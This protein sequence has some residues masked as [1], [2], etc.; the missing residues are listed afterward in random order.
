MPAVQVSQLRTDILEILDATA[1]GRYSSALL[2]RRIGIAQERLYALL[3]RCGG[4][5]DWLTLTL[6]IVVDPTA[7]GYSDLRELY[8]SPIAAGTVPTHWQLPDDRDDAGTEPAPPFYRLRSIS[9]V[10]SFTSSGTDRYRP[11]STWSGRTTQ[12]TRCPIRELHR[13]VE[14]R[15]WTYADPPRYRL[16]Y[17]TQQ[18]G[19]NAA[20][21]ITFDRR[22]N[23]AAGFLI[24]YMPDVTALSDYLALPPLWAEFLISDVVA[25]LSERNREFD[26]VDRYR[27]RQREVAE[28]IQA[29]A[30][31]RD[32]HGPPRIQETDYIGDLGD[33]ELRDRLT[34]RDW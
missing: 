18:D 25:A 26:L 3:A 4:D 27:A 31:N 11:I 16:M 1:N 30:Q 6:G 34:Y 5:D 2:D 8:M 15:A 22:S 32:E 13:D 21:T 9:I 14:K 28:E 12:L 7:T 20:P 33:Q 10:E 24:D 17:R 19:D 23:A 29:T